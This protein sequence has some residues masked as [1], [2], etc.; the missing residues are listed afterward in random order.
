MLKGLQGKETWELKVALAKYVKYL[1]G[2]SVYLQVVERKFVMK[3]HIK[4]LLKEVMNDFDFKE[5]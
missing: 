4:M 5:K 2:L 1:D 3:K